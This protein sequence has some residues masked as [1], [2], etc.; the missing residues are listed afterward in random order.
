MKRARKLFGLALFACLAFCPVHLSAARLQRWLYYPVNLWVNSNVTNLVSVLNRASAAGYTHLLLSDSKFSHLGDMDARYFAN[1]N[2]LRSVASSLG[3]EIVPAVFPIG[4]SNDLLFNDPN[5]IEAL[6]VTNA[7]LVVSNG[8]A[9]CQADPPVAF[10]GA[11]FSNLALWDWHDATVISSNGAA[12]IVNPNG[13]NARIVQSITV[14]PF[15]QYHISVRVKTLSFQGTP[16]VKVLA[17]GLAL[18]YNPLGV[19]QIQDWTTHHVVFN[20]L[21]NR[22]VAVYFGCWDGSTGTLFWDDAAIEEVAFLNLVRRPGASLSVQVENGP[23]LT[24]GTDFPVFKDP[25]MGVYPWNGCYDVYHAA[26]WLQVSLTNGTRLRASYCHAVTVYDDQAMICPSEP[27]TT[28]LLWDQARR[29]HAA[30]QA[31][32]YM[33]SHDEI[34]VMNWCP[35]CQQRHLDAGTMLAD[36]ARTCINILR[37]VNPGG[38]IYVWSDMFDPFHNAQAN[39]YLV[40]GNLTNSWLGLDPQITILPWNIATRTNT[41]QFFSGRGHSQVIAGYYDSG[42]GQIATWL[43]A[44]QT[45]PGILGVMYTTWAGQYTD[46]ASFGDVVS[47]FEIHHSWQLAIRRLPT[48]PQIEFP[49]ISGHVYTVM[50]ST[51]LT[52]WTPWTNFTSSAPFARCPDAS[53][54]RTASYYQSAT[55]P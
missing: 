4:Y 37:Q 49:A 54:G 44:A 3:I 36:N 15:R 34:R 47:D 53:A 42:P 23:F 17:S 38:R 16:E 30:F 19:Q 26:P 18:N 12:C 48:S 11:D 52:A 1:V 33:M 14:A 2:Y 43:N 20:S 25:S 46:L 28:N 31:S 55:M 39:Y 45:F 50:R 32:G 7:L 5:L 35:A 6:P 10:R 9:L 21:T 40:R 29:V 13:Q 27:A 41:F 51:N 24:E 22:S 8:I